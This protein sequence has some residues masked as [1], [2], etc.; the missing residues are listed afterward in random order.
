MWFKH[1]HLFKLK[2]SFQMPQDKLEEQLQRQRKTDGPRHQVSTLG[3]VSPFG[4][5]SDLLVLAQ[6][7]FYLLTFS[8]EEKIIPSVVVNEKAVDKIASVEQQECRKISKNERKKIKED[9]YHSLLPLAFS[10]TK[11]TNLIIDAQE[12]WIL[13]DC[14][15]RAH[16]E[17]CIE[18]LRSALGSLPLQPIDTYQDASFVMTSWLMNDQTPDHLTIATRCE[19]FDDR[20]KNTTIKFTDHD[21]Q[22]ESVINHLKKGKKVRQVSVD[23]HEK[24][25]FSLNNDYSLQR[26]R[27]LDMDE[28]NEVFDSKEAPSPEIRLDTEFA[29]ITPLYRQLIQAMF[30]WFGGLRA[31]EKSDQPAKIADEMFE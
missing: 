26:I 20:Q 8:I 14:S 27:Y 25:S 6:N 5:H 22:A 11:S 29:L 19:M 7:D 15:S 21:L 16:A 28:L 3:W 1:I 9:I 23:W 10:R 2:S 30:T 12:G 4:K 24:I 17:S 13:V 31:P 18:Q